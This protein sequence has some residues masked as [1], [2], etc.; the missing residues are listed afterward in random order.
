MK[1]YAS[2]AIALA[3]A[4]FG[5]AFAGSPS[6]SL[7]YDYIGLD[8]VQVD[9]DNTDAD[10][11]GI[12]AGFYSS[13]SDSLFL[14]G[15]YAKLDVDGGS[16]ANGGNLGLGFRVPLAATSDFNA[17][18]SLEYANGGNGVGS[19]IGF[20]VHT[21][22][23]F[24][25]IPALEG[26]VG[27]S[28]FDVQDSDDTVVGASLRWHITSRFSAGGGYAVGSDSKSTSLGVRFNF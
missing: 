24:L 23:R 6:T 2:I 12:A 17:G 1:K 25:F 13:V 7:S 5:A 8:L 9:I 4:P 3:V 27:V 16:S 26:E 28:H 10:A 15:G 22:F 19:D 18:V 21:A 14:F 11:D 20:G